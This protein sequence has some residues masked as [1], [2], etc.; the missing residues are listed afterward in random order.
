MNRFQL[1]TRP[2]LAMTFGVAFS[3]IIGL[4]ACEQETLTLAESSQELVSLEA[5]MDATFEDVDELSLEAME[6][7]D[8]SA[9]RRSI[10]AIHRLMDSSCVT[11]THDTAAKS[12]TVDFGTGC[13]GPHGKTIAGQ[14]LITYN[15]WL[16]RPGAVRTVTL[17]SFYVDGVHVEGTKTTTNTMTS[18]LDPISLNTVLTN[19]QMTW[20]S[21]AIATREFDRTKTWIRGLNP[22]QDEF[23]VDG[24]TETVRQN[25]D[26]VR[27]DITST[28]IRK[29]QCRV[30]Q[31]IRIPVEGEKLIQ[32]TGEDDV[33][34][35][36]GNGT[37]DDQV[38]VTVNGNSQVINL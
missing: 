4:S 5:E 15:K 34:M 3:M 12:I 14:I 8:F 1:F 18:M 6:V 21:G 29:R 31:G 9:G 25:G 35:D 36:F 32:K 33:L 20:P 2:A 17:D 19:G 10:R 7:C 22:S 11:I 16:Y 30:S 28:L 23:H 38:T 13:T 24:Y 37:C 27:V 26:T